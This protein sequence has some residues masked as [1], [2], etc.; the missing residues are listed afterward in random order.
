MIS[1]GYDRCVQWSKWDKLVY[2]IYNINIKY[3]L[4]TCNEYTMIVLSM[5]NT[6]KIDMLYRIDN[7]DKIYQQYQS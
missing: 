1:F 7:K 4:E 5:Y 3:I 2:T 6:N